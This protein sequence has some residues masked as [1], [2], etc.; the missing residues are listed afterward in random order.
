MLL[1]KVELQYS[2][3]LVIQISQVYVSF[4]YQEGRRV[5][6]HYVYSQLSMRSTKSTNLFIQPFLST[7]F[8]RWGSFLCQVPW[9]YHHYTPFSIV[10][11]L[12]LLYYNYCLY[13]SPL[14]GNKNIMSLWFNVF[15]TVQLVFCVIGIYFS[16]DHKCH[17]ILLLK[18]PELSCMMRS[19][20]LHHLSPVANSKMP[21]ICLP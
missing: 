2:S 13:L 11:A 17:H 10:N 6:F 18:Y 14:H 20:R 9:K 19:Q 12:F 5:L 7:G 8:Q 15:I 4:I 3:L 21:V 16:S 1:F